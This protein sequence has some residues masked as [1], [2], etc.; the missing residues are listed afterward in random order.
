MSWTTHGLVSSQFGDKDTIVEILGLG[1]SIPLKTLIKE[2]L[3]FDY[4]FLPVVAIAH[5]G[6]VLLFLFVF[7]YGIK[8]FNFQKR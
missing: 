7:A 4:D 3:D 5:V 6:W 1:F 2:V 8:F